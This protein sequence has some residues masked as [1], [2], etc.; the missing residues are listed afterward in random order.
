MRVIVH[1]RGVRAGA[2]SLVYLAAFAAAFAARAG[3]GTEAASA[4]AKHA[5]FETFREAVSAPIFDDLEGI[6]KRGKI[7]VAVTYSKTHYFVDKGQQRGFAYE[8]LVEF[9]KF[10]R[11]RFAKKHRAP[12]SIV[13]M[14]V[15]RNELFARLVDGRADMAVANLTITRERQLLADFTTPLYSGAREVVVTGPGYPPLASADDLSGREV[16]VRPSSSFREHLDALNGRLIAAG[17]AEIK[18][19]LADEHLETE[20]LLEMVHAGLI[21]ATVADDYIADL[22]KSIFPN[23]QIHRE[24]PISEGTSIG[25]AVRKTAPGLLA[26]AN[27]FLAVHRAGTSF[28]NVLRNRYLKDPN[29]ARRAMDAKEVQKFRNTVKLF[30]QYGEQYKFDHLLILA[31]AYQ[32]S[33]LD[34]DCKSRAGALGVMQVLPSTGTMMKVGDIKRLEP[35]VHAGVKYL[36]SIIDKYFSDPEIS[37]YDRTLFAFAAYNAGPTRV[38]SLRKKAARQRLDPNVWFGNV[39]IVASQVVGSETVHYVSNISKYY[40]AYRMIENRRDERDPQAVR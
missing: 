36:R 8:N 29:W 37:D 4:P 1:P 9:E 25:W 21:E 32:E 6:L 31:Q 28:G 22:W 11:K 17:K 35:N 39:E 24:A 18:L 26:Q 30:R 10:L 2:L 40:L 14:P 33:R 23:L 34:Q 7:R 15:P 12:V 20:D 38:Q 27:G 19:L 5:T 13:F 16:V 3:T